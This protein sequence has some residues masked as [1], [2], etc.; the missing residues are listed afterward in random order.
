MVSLNDDGM[1]PNL[2]SSNGSPNTGNTFNIDESASPS[3][4]EEQMFRNPEFENE[5]VK[6][7]E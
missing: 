6:R 4:N 1:G 2:R 5:E 7:E 3:P